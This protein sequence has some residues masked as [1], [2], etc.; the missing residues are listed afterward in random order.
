MCTYVRVMV[1]SR[2]AGNA[3]ACRW[4]SD[5]K[6]VC[7]VTQLVV[8]REY[9]QRGLALGLLCQLRQDR[10]DIYGLMSSHPAACL[11]AIKA[12]GSPLKPV[13]LNYIREHAGSIMAVSPVAYV[14][15]ARL[16]GSLF[17]HGNV[18]GLV[19]S[20]DSGFFVDH[21]EPLEALAW[22][23]EAMDWPFGELHDGHEFIVLIES[24]RRA[25]S[26]L[27]SSK[28]ASKGLALV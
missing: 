18:S 25:R 19:S 15:D 22:V 14:K 3:F 20:V 27:Q 16:R 24:R 23:Q 21:Q 4:M 7:W 9:R 13:D 6:T 12:F 1:N 5:G 28:S 17:E 2:L 11:A 26:T 10:D 8:H